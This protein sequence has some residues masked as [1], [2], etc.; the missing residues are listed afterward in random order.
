MRKPIETL[1]GASYDVCVI[2]AGVNGA[3]SAQHLAAAG[4]SVLLVDKNDFGAGSSS[5]SS[6]LL[7]C[8][9]RYFAPGASV[10]EFVKHPPR[11]ATALRMARL[12]MEARRQLVLT[13]PER[14]R[15]LKFH[16]PIWSDA[17][18][19]PW[20][21]R[22]ALQ[23]LAAMAPGDVPLDHRVI[24]PDQA[25]SIPLVGALRD[26]DRLQGIGAFREY[27]FEWPER[28]C[29][30]AALDAERLGAEI[31]NYTEASRMSARAD[32]WDVE[33]RDVASGGTA[34][35]SCKLLLNMAGIWIDRVNNSSGSERPRKVLGT[36]GIHFM[37][38]LPPDCADI[39]IVTFNRRNEPLYCIP[40]RGMHYFGPTETVY[41]GDLDDIRAEDDEIEDL[42]T[43]ANHLLPSLK[44]K[45]ADILF[46]WAGVR[47]LSYDPALPMGKR[48]RD[49]HDL[50]AIGMPNA[51]A[52]TAGPIMTHR[53][54]GTEMVEHVRKRFAPSRGKQQID[55]S[56]RRFPENQNSPPIVEDW[57]IAKLADLRH[58]ALNEHGT[59]LVDILFRRVGVGWT[60]TMGSLAAERAAEIVGEALG[61]DD[62]RRRAEA[63]SYR[64]HVAHLHRVRDI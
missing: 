57:P 63:A 11:F 42:L 38:Q 27:Q 29:I 40:W 43:E 12:A 51:L 21:V 19:R 47:P 35:V 62:T 41:E 55:Y 46:T 20:Q 14:A 48:S 15:A 58:A 7:H 17:M 61:W 39:G 22:L 64:Q 18:Y 37:V 50:A 6:R 24:A 44:L 53:S 49:V 2:G 56:A 28:L 33:L 3:S 13:A 8:G 59:N 45:R 54:A 60:R 34:R 36:K 31:R 4:Y 25:R 30:D 5:R 23:T 26:W 10:L 9:L 1:A 52:M 16:F 32:G